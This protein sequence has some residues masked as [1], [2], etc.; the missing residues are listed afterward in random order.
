METQRGPRTRFV[1]GCCVFDG[2]G[3]AS[4]GRGR[5]DA[6]CGESSGRE[7][8]YVNDCVE[9]AVGVGVVCVDVG[10]AGCVSGSGFFVR[11]VGF[12]RGQRGVCFNR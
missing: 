6:Q 3:I 9:S 5:R 4:R 7:G 12:F 2:M 10:G 11:S 1:L 8:E